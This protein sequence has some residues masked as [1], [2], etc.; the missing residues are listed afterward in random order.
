MIVADDDRRGRI[1]ALDFHFGFGFN[2][3]FQDRWI[4]VL[5]G[6]QCDNRFDRGRSRPGSLD[7]HFLFLDGNNRWLG[8]GLCYNSL[9]DDF[10]PADD[11]LLLTTNNTGVQGD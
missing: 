8:N 1:D 4:A 2:G 7:E 11:Q 10:R 3:R 9:F 5:L 6:R